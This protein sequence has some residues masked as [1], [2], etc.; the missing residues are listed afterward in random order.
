[1]TAIFVFAATL[2]AGTAAAAHADDALAPP[3]SEQIEADWLRQ[4][5]VRSLPAAP[6]GRP[7]ASVT[8]VADA[9]GGCDGIKDGL[10]GFHTTS[11]ENP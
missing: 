5:Y 7:K 2:L 10:F 4:D 8:P 6:P 9:A 3:S 11:E 1:M